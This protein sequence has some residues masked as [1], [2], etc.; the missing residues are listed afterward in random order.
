MPLLKVSFWLCGSSVAASPC[1]DQ[2]KFLAAPF[3]ARLRNAVGLRNLRSQADAKPDKSAKA[4]LPVFK[5]YREAD[6]KFYFKFIDANGRLLLQSGAFDSPKDAGQTIRLL[7]GEGVSLLAGL[8][9]TVQRAD[10]VTP[11]DV[12]SA[13][14]QLQ[15]TS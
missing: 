4:A 8:A 9:S 5:Q 3:A 6:G 10:G 2:R 7:Q 1:E 14:A 11:D 12:A 15:A 13:L